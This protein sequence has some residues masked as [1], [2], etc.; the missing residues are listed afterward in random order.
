[1]KGQIRASFS[2]EAASQVGRFRFGWRV[3]LDV[4]FQWRT[5]AVYG[6]YWWLWVMEK[7][8]GTLEMVLEERKRRKWHFS[9]A[10]RKAKAKTL[11]CFYSQE[12]KFSSHF[13]CRIEDNNGQ[14]VEKCSVKL[15]T[16]FREDPMVNAG[17]EVFL[18][19]QLHVASLKSFNKRLPWEASSWDFFRKLSWEASL[20][21]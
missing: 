8:F 19:R 5:M 10:T 20:R 14:I 4:G 3:P 21:S 9:K 1:M 7:V 18:L 15:Q 12:R 16:K 13:R 6:G 17:C 2:T 11:K